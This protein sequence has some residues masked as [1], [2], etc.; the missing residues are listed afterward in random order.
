[1]KKQDEVAMRQDTGGSKPER[2]EENEQTKENLHLMDEAI[3]AIHGVNIKKGNG[4]GSLKFLFVVI[5]AMFV[6]V[7][8]GFYLGSRSQQS[9]EIDQT[10]VD[11]LAE[12]RGVAELTKSEELIAYDV[13]LGMPKIVARYKHWRLA[14][15]RRKAVEAYIPFKV[16]KADCAGLLAANGFSEANIN[17]SV[18]YR[19]CREKVVAQLQS[20]EI[21]AKTKAMKETAYQQARTSYDEKITLLEAARQKCSDWQEAEQK[22]ADLQNTKQ[23]KWCS[24]FRQ[25]VAPACVGLI[26]FIASL[27]LIIRYWSE[28]KRDGLAGLSLV[29]LLILVMLACVL[30][31]L[32]S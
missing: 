15:A 28:L 9:A 31:S 8:V 17:D 3:N 18:T 23:E 7:G 5:L 13:A 1:M 19:Q 12:E 10:Q 26:V 27:F 29:L 4:R 20:F 24:T 11:K 21:E 22:L 25:G 16:L 14:R 2:F 32:V 30:I 6:L